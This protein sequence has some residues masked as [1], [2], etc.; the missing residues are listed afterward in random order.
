MRCGQRRNSQWRVGMPSAPKLGAA[1]RLLIAGF[2]VLLVVH[3]PRVNCAAQEPIDISG[4]WS[5][6]FGFIYEIEQD[7]YSFTWHVR[8]TAETGEGVIDYVRGV[9]FLFVEWDGSNGQGS[10]TGYPFPGG[11]VPEGLLEAL[12]VSLDPAFGFPS[13]DRVEAILWQNLNTFYRNR[14][15]T[16]KPEYRTG[17]PVTIF[18]DA[19][20]YEINWRFER[21]DEPFAIFDNAGDAVRTSCRDP[22]IGS[23]IAPARTYDW[24]WDQVLVLCQAGTPNPVRSSRVPPGR[25]TVKVGVVVV[26]SILPPLQYAAE[27][28]ILAPPPVA[29]PGGPYTA[30]AGEVI[31][32]DGR[33]SQGIVA[34]YLWDLGDESTATGP[35]VEHA[36]PAAGTYTIQLTVVAEDRQQ[37]SET[38]TAIVHSPPPAPVADP[39][40]PYSGFV[41]EL[42]TFDGGGSQGAITAYVWDFGDGSTAGGTTPE[43]AYANPGI[44]TVELTVVAEDRQEDRGSTTVTVVEPG[45][46]P[47]AVPGGPYSGTVNVP[48]TFDGS[49][50]RGDIVRYLWDFGDETTGSGATPRHQYQEAGTYA[51]HL[52]VVARDDQEDAAT[53]TARLEDPQPPLLI[54]APGGPYEG[55][56]EEPIG[57]DGT[58]S[59]G[60]IVE[61]AW[62]FGDGSSGRGPSVQHAYA[63]EDSYTVRLTVRDAAGREVA[64]SVVVRIRNDFPLP[65]VLLAIAAAVVLCAGGA[66]LR[67]AR[68]RKRL[69]PEA[70][71]QEPQGPCR[72]PPSIRCHKATA[73][74]HGKPWKVSWLEATATKPERTKRLDDTILK[75]VNAAVTAV[76]RRGAERAELEEHVKRIAQS[77]L[78]WIQVWL[79]AAAE[80][81]DVRIRAGIEDG[82]VTAEFTP[83]ICRRGTWKKLRHKAWKREQSISSKEDVGG[84]VGLEVPAGD[85]ATDIKNRLEESLSAFIRKV[86]A[87][88]FKERKSSGVS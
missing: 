72:P 60:N 56:P 17:E 46:G 38:T 11:S 79:S 6:T 76:R 7:G 12:W 34:E 9:P 82:T 1:S 32:F 67:L 24:T 20:A 2:L 64:N 71:E 43:H 45:E 49:G 68:W 22:S 73:K 69:E 57:F 37:H 58:G 83:Y 77:V 51:V 65:L 16:D 4:V 25:Y 44:Y 29:V 13:A 14:L 86:A 18:F 61:Y 50:S 30:E 48:L 42:I 85:E 87:L 33:E 31:L 15:R 19:P 63:T 40:G 80:P 84:I 5:S 41:N 10:D 36:Y 81:V 62:D 66:G 27:I 59:R 39:N 8:S 26:D 70:T 54:A 3:L 74:W 23:P 78:E 53:T 88:P 28:E 21:E 52:A 75:E 47:V 55:S 35:T